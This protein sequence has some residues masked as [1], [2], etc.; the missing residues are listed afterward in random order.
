MGWGRGR[1]GSGGS[2]LQRGPTFGFYYPYA[3]GAGTQ[4][5]ILP[6]FPMNVEE[7]T[8]AGEGSDPPAHPFPQSWLID[9]L[10]RQGLAPLQMD[11]SHE[12]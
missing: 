12:G 1:G 7:A 4:D 8:V 2:V 9:I 11:S 3:L 6:R 10:S 5:P